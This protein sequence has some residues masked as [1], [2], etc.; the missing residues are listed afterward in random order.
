MKRL[1][2]DCGQLL[3]SKGSW[4][5]KYIGDSVMA[6]WVHEEGA[7]TPREVAALFDSVGHLAR[8]IGSVS[9]EFAIVPPLAFGVGVNSGLAVTEPDQFSHVALIVFTLRG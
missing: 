5:Q 1:F 9:S 3:T 4:G 7:G 6:F 2:H 8:I